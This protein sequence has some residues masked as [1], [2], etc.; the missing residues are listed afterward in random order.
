MSAETVDPNL[1]SMV[2]KD[3]PWDSVIIVNAPN[4]QEALGE[5]AD[6]SEEIDQRY[7]KQ[8][9]NEPDLEIHQN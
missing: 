5:A 4:A 9:Q 7:Q 1:K 8:H 2:N 6:A 3:H